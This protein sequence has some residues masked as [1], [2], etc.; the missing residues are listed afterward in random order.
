MPQVPELTKKRV[1]AQCDAFVETTLK[2]RAVQAPPEDPQFNYIVDLYTL[3]YGDHFI[4][5]ARYRCVF[6]ECESEFY[7]VRYTR[8]TY[9]GSD[10]YTLSYMRHNGKWQKVFMGMSLEN[11]LAT[12]EGNSIFWPY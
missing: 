1:K 5:C 8:L 11:C 7:E 9:T 2:P 6:P 12:I 10:I 3:W 4:F